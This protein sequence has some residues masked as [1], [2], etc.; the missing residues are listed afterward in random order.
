VARAPPR[1]IV[2][3]PA[4]FTADLLQLE[5]RRFVRKRL[6]FGRCS[7]YPNDHDYFDLTE[8]VAARF[9]VHPTSVF[10]VGSAKLG[11]SIAPAKRYAAFH[12]GSDI[13]VVIVSD[14]LFDRIWNEFHAAKAADVDWRRRGDFLKYLFQGWLRPDYFPDVRGHFADGWWEFFQAISKDQPAKVTG[15]IYRTW[16]FFEAYQSRCVRMCADAESRR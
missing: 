1:A 9:D 13:D 8:R 4:D 2:V 5:T 6:V 10:A 14:R 11:F 3:P 16:D 12:D 15:A 7:I